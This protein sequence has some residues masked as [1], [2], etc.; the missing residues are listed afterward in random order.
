MV[1]FNLQRIEYSA[2]RKIL[3]YSEMEK[4]YPSGEY[5]LIL[6]T[7]HSSTQHITDQ[8]EPICKKTPSRTA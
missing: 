2:Y 4:E 3:A 1:L 7:N 8:Y 5:F 6:R